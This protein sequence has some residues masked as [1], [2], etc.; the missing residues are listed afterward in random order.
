MNSERLTI[1][2]PEAFKLLGISKNHGYAL[3]HRNEF[4]L[5]VIRAG[6]RYLIPK[7]SVEKLL[8]PV[9]CQL[10]DKPDSE[11]KE[12]TPES[13]GLSDRCRGGNR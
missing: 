3:I 4:C 5:P 8:G 12:A 7:A 2:A 11:I 13:I 6:Q 9:H 10:I 1:D